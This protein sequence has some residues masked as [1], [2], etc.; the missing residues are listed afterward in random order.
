M[1]YNI[2]QRPFARAELIGGGCCKELRGRVSFYD[3]GDG[4]LVSARVINLPAEN[5][6]LGFHLHEGGECSGNSADEFSAA[7]GHYNPN[8]LSHPSHSGDFP[9][10]LNCSGYACLEFFTNRLL[11]SEIIGKTVIIHSG[12]DDF[13]TQPSGDSGRKI[14]CAVVKRI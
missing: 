3:G 12:R 6:F 11:P 13:T 9:P 14:A 4:V 8:H 7:G 10:L 2:Y 5:S 1:Y